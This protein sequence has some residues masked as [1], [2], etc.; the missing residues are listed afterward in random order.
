MLPVDSFLT[1]TD[2][3]NENMTAGNF[4]PSK[5]A[6]WPRLKDGVA[7]PAPTLVTASTVLTT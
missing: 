7:F 2:P 6:L 3:V 1:D 5:T 4:F